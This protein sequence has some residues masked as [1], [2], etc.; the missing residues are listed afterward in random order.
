ME[1]LSIT[2]KN[3]CSRALKVEF[4]CPYVS[5]LFR[6]KYWGRFVC[7]VT[8]A[9]KWHLH[10]I[11]PAHA[12]CHIGLGVMGRLWMWNSFLNSFRLRRFRSFGS[13]ETFQSLWSNRAV[14][15]CCCPFWT[16]PSVQFKVCLTQAYDGCFAY[17][18]RHSF[19]VTSFATD[20]LHERKGETWRGG[21]HSKRTGNGR[22]PEAK[23]FG[24]ATSKQAAST[25]SGPLAG[26]GKGFIFLIQ[27]LVQ[28]GSL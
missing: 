27:F 7:S 8:N 15:R 20:L 2:K 23:S 3:K 13:V 18:I 6:R 24:Y 10:Y 21:P 1:S 19:T 16:S 11:L 9:V 5:F 22:I 28:L 17:T 14:S 4:G 12:V 26:R 25:A